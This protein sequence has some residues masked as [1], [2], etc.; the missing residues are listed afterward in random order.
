M[1]S[2]S[3]PL[4][5]STGSTTAA[6]TARSPMTT[7]TSPRPASRPPTTVKQHPPN[8]RS[9]NSHSS[10]ETRGGSV[11]ADGEAGAGVGRPDTDGVRRGVLDLQ[12][13]VLPRDGGFPAER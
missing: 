2:S 10:H 9:P 1:T 8:R 13:G 7:P 12:V 11:E 4:A 3:P 6:S 5:T